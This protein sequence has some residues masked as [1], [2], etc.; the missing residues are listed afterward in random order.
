MHIEPHRLGARSEPVVHEIERG[1][2]RRY[3]RALGLTNAIHYDV[4][5]ARAEG[6]RDLVAPPTYAV[7]LL[8]W[9][10]PGLNLPPAGVLHGEQAFE[11]GADPICAGDQIEVTGWVADVKTRGG[12]HI[13][14]IESEGQHAGR[15]QAFH[16]RAVLIVTEEVEHA[17]RG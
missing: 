10:I 1:S 12:M 9:N 16:A 17:S 15:G 14:G 5:K 6:Y 7:T 4:E 13:I 2:I 3:A 8:P 11:W